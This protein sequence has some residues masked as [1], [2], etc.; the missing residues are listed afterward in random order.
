MTFVLKPPRYKPSTDKK[1]QSL[2]PKTK[3]VVLT[4][5]VWW[6][7]K[8]EGFNIREVSSL[9]YIIGPSFQLAGSGFS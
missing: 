7:D 6:E 8:D 3:Q 4:M 1:L 9:L 2:C 5:K